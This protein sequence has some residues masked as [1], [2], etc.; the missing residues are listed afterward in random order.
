[1]NVLLT[2]R[3]GIG[4]STVIQK[5]I[6]TLGREGCAGFWTSERRQ[7]GIRVGFSIQTIEGA[8]GTLADVSFHNGPQV[9]KYTVNVAHLN[10]IAIPSL[11]RARESGKLIVVDEIASMELKSPRFAS[12]IRLC[13]D[14][15]RVLGTL[16]L[17]GGSFQDEVRSRSDVRI[18]E[19]TP[20]NRDGLPSQ[21]IDAL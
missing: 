15:G 18:I 17:R 20:E 11:Q 8:V 3:P 21:I 16:Q 5:I 9:G 4:K 1:M 19:V 12:E 10:Q 14:T 2:G 7:D 6:K 13:L